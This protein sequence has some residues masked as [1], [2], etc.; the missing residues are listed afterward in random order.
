MDDRLRIAPLAEQDILPCAALLATSEPWTRYGITTD[1]AVAL[2]RRALSDGARVSVA[3]LDART[4]GFV[5]Y[6]A[7]GGFG[8]S[9]YLKLL[10]V[11]ADAR[12]HGIGAAL[13]DHAERQT[14]A[15][16]QRDLILLVSEFNRAAQR[17]YRRH[18]Y[19]RVGMLQ[20]YVVPGIAE[21]IFHK[22]LG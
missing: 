5:W 15:D 7:G 21:L 6:I 14:L 12:G 20:D 11:S 22:R 4:A 1:A 10:G 16:R 9:G 3:R 8:L 19:R 18:G 13:L 2:W 17:F